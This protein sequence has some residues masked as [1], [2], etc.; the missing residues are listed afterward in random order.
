MSVSAYSIQMP[1]SPI[2]P[3]NKVLDFKHLNVTADLKT[4]HKLKINN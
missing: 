4:A 1:C 2:L 3:L